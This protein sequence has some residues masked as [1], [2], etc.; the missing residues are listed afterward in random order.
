MSF[1]PHTHVGCDKTNQASMDINR[2]SIHTPT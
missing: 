2:V 1:N